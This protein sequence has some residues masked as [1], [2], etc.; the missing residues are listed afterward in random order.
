MGRSQHLRRPCLAHV[1]FVALIGAFFMM[2]P[3]LYLAYEFFD[4]VRLLRE[5]HSAS[6][7]FELVLSLSCLLCWAALY[8]SYRAVSCGNRKGPW[9]GLTTCGAICPLAASRRRPPD[10]VR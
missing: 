8:L 2:V 5:R 10:G 6:G 4:E 3:V 9:N 1:P 7:L